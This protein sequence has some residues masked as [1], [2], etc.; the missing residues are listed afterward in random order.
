MI[1]VEFILLLLS[2]IFFI[3]IAFEWLYSEKRGKALYQWRDTAA[4]FGLAALHQ[5]GDFIAL[6]LLLPLMLW[7]SQFALF[8]IEFSAL[9]LFLLFIAQD[10]LYYWFHRCSHRVR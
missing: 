7:L 4:N 6:L 5:A 3:F 10:F 1:P 8:S 2:P 9:N